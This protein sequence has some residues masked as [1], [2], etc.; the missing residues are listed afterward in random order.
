MMRYILQIFTGNYDA[1]LYTAAQIL[2]RLDDVTARL[3]IDKLIIGWYPDAQLYKQVGAYLRNKNIDMFLWLPVFSETGEFVPMDAA[4]DLWGRPIQPPTVQEGES[5]SFCCPSSPRNLDAVKTVY[6]RHFADCGF[7]GVFLDRIRTHSFVGGVEG[8]L[9]CG[10]ARCRALYDAHG[11]SLDDV[12]TDFERDRDR[13]WDV[14]AADPANGFVFRSESTARF[15]K[16]KAAVVADGVRELC[17]HFHSKGLEVGLDLYAPL[18][19]AFVGQD[20]ALLVQ[21]ADF[22]KPMLYRRTDAPAGIAYEYALLKQLAP[23]A[24]GY[25][26]FEWDA[27]F[28]E[29]QLTPLKALPC[30]V[31]PGIEINHRADI[32]PTDDAYVTESLRVLRDSGMTGA[33]LSWD[34]MLAPDAHLQAAA[35]L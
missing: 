9:S 18:M 12:A 2:E 31:Y 8:V 22:I 26:S 25:P 3:T 35:T 1:P 23:Q 16:A 20:Y 13:I 34:V 19:S 5:F 10:C 29:A 15:L 11:V 4:V 21:D 7:A 28:L 32:A 30:A 24:T 17:R 14:V 33:T 6:D 27:A